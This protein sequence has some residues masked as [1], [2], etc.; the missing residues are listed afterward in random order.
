MTLALTD[1]ALKKLR[2]RRSIP[3]TVPRPPKGQVASLRKKLGGKHTYAKSIRKGVESAVAAEL[4]PIR[5]AAHTLVSRLDADGLREA[6]VEVLGAFLCMVR[7]LNVRLPASAAVVEARGVADAMEAQ[8]HAGHFQLE[9]DSG[10]WLNEVRLV[11]GSSYRG[12]WKEDELWLPI[13]TAIAAADDETYARAR[14]RALPLRARADLLDRAYLA[15]AFPDEPWADEDLAACLADAS[16]DAHRY[17]ILL[18]SCRSPRLVRE[19]LVRQPGSLPDHALE[20]AV[21][22][23]EDE[24]IA[25]LGD[26]LPGLL[27]RPKYGPLLKTPPRDVATALACFRSRAAA[28]RLAPYAGHAVLGV[29][30]AAYFRDAPELGDA[31]ATG[32]TGKAGREVVAQ[33][34]ARREPRNEGGVEAEESAVPAVLRERPWRPRKKRAQGAVVAG[35]VIAYAQGGPLALVATHGLAALPGFLA[36]ERLTNLD[37]EEAPLHMAAIS[38]FES[39]RI[40]PLFARIATRRKAQRRAALAWLALRPRL[41]ATGLVPAAVGEHGAAR[42]EA[43]AALVHLAGRGAHEEIRAAA[44]S[45]GERA[46]A[47]IDALLAR[48]PLAIDARPPKL[49]D[50][51]RVADLPAVRV[52]DG[53]RLPTAAIEALVEMLSI[54]RLDDPYAGIAV[55]REAC[56]PGSLASFT[57]A[58]LEQWLLAGAPGR[59]EWMLH[60]I[61][62]FPSDETTRRIA[63]LAREWARRDRAKAARA[64]ETLA[65]LATDTALLHLGH[66]AETSR[67][68]DLRELA[69]SLLDEAAL[70]RGIT[71]DELEDRTVPD[72]GLGPDGTL[73]VSFGE[74][75]FVASLDARLALVV[76]DAGGAVVGGLPRK[77]KGDDAAM[78]K[79]AVAR[80]RALRTDATA[81][82][83]RQ[84]RRLE[85]AMVRGRALASRDFVELVVRH[86]LL[87]HLARGLVWEA[88]S[89][90]DAIARFRV[91]RTRSE[92]PTPSARSGL[93]SSPTTS[94]SS[95]SSSSAARSS[96]ARRRSAAV[97]RRL[98]SRAS[99]SR[100]RAS[101]AWPS[102]AAFVGARRA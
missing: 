17:R 49:P 94:S 102:L 5:R 10:G 54:A 100:R 55:V 46:L 36:N 64:C 32:A 66:I 86:P 69:R 56:E 30:V 8:L 73:P 50:F 11:R 22:L 19:F 53:A 12:N 16:L 15:Y 96:T 37:Y 62:H 88:L 27:V 65:T 34:A 80:L 97:P 52:H 3:A 71:R 74:R 95:P 77:Q 81:I 39:P 26:A 58:L 70:A 25:I 57:S 20:V 89:G 61:A 9:A 51:L 40:A 43:E 60:A 44:E 42:D 2:P 24:A 18:S 76:R 79:A 99:P 63:L 47:A 35:L 59:H 90:S 33:L 31:L 21:S 38:S 82:A 85:R 72:L 45:Y 29:I 98:A 75:G 48:D 101:S 67:F 93:P 84:I 41:A 87:M 28:E 78:A 92:S 83:E 23:P 7:G 1:A 14:E 6:S 13:R 91:S 4:A 68:N